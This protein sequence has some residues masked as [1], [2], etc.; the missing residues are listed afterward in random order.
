M[1]LRSRLLFGAYLVLAVVGVGIV[2]IARGEVA[3]GVLVLLLAGF[4]ISGR[5]LTRRA[6]EN[7]I[8]WILAWIAVVFA[9]QGVAEGIAGSATRDDPLVVAE[10][11][12]W[13]SEWVW[14]F[15]LGLAG[16]ALPLLF[17]DGKLA[18][19]RWLPVAWA[20]IV[21]VLLGAVGSAIAPGPLPADAEMTVTNP[22]GI[23][24]AQGVSGALTGVGTGL[25]VIG[26]VGGTASLVTRLRRSTGVERQQLKW[27]VFVVAVMASGLLLAGLA[28]AEGEDSQ[29][30]LV[31]GSIG[32]MSM[33]LF[34]GIGIPV[35]TGIAVLRHRLYDIDVVI[36]RTVI[37]AALSATLLASYLGLVLLLGLAL[38][39]LT[40]ESDLAIAGSTLAVAALFRPL[41]A[42]IQHAVDRRFYRRRFD[43]A[44]TVEAF[45]G[46]LR[47]QVELGAVEHEL[48][49]VATETMQ[50]AHV[51]LW[52]RRGEATP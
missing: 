16:V 44:R 17:P 8:G 51:T 18:S 24:G 22:F 45:S 3:E 1:E 13:L 41:R 49:T 33:L 14:Y 50:P 26:F 4:A 7:R 29:L 40:E 6:P 21:G 43:S 47:D 9:V 39:P 46:R 42:R 35:A 30:F 23:A 19:R 52:L 36:R 12:A 25:I 2:A 11:A 48:R 5:L 37:Y 10:L 38:G 27:F 32:W 34:M 15:W 31:I 20:G 28:V